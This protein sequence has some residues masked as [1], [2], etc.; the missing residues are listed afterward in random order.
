MIELGWLDR[1]EPI[2][3][4]LAEHASDADAMVPAPRELRQRFAITQ[5]EFGIRGLDTAAVVEMVQN[6][7]V[8]PLEVMVALESVPTL[9]NG[10]HIDDSFQ[11]LER[12]LQTD[13][14][15]PYDWLKLDRRLQRLRKDGRLGP[16][17][18]RARQQFEQLLKDLDEAKRRGELPPYLEAPISQVKSQV[19]S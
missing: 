3:K 15:I 8:T 5:K 10:G 4:A 11:V 6:P 18:N 17:V 19:G 1:A 16:V 12:A 2:F 14:V 7:K 9:A 13:V